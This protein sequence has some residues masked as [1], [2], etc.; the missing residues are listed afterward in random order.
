VAIIN[1]S[2]INKITAEQIKKI[3]QNDK[4]VTIHVIEKKTKKQ[5]HPQIF[6][7]NAITIE[8]QNT[9]DSI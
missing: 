9:I 5:N 8:Q 7:D 2:W 4:T 6:I 3:N 1:P